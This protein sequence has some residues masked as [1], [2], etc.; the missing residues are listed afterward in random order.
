MIRKYHPDVVAQLV[1]E[2]LAKVQKDVER[3]EL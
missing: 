3:I 2:R 1:Y